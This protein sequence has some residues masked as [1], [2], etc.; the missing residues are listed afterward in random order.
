MS[1]DNKIF[2]VKQKPML[3]LF[4][5]LLDFKEKVLCTILIF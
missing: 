2:D 3:E 5:M 1:K 4:E